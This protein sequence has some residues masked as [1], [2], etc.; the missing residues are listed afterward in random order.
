MI[1]LGLIIVTLIVGWVVIRSYRY[2]SAEQGVRTPQQTQYITRLWE[3][4]HTAMK[5]QRW[6]TAERALLKILKYDHKN[7][8]AYNQLGMIYVRSG[9]PENAA[10]CFDIASSLAPSVSSL[11]NLGLVHYQTGNLH[12]A[13]RALEKVVDLE[14]TTK[15]LLVFA[16]ILQKDAR[17]KRVVEVMERVVEMDPSDRNLQYLAEA[18]EAAGEE[19]KAETTR[20]RIMQNQARAPQT[21]HPQQASTPGS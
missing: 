19:N 4:A 6:D 9:Q 3:Y 13:A 8:S 12:D 5:R 17:H 15:R 18:Y 2:D 11:Y 21:V 20:R 16:K 14:P 10:V 7:T 1:E